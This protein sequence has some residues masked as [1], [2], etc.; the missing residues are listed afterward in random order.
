MA[1]VRAMISVPESARASQA[2]AILP[3]ISSDAD[4]DLAVEVSA[5]FGRGLV[6]ELQRTGAGAFVHAGGALNVEG[7][8]EAV[9]GVHHHRQVDAVADQ[10]HGLGHLGRGCQADVGPA[11]AGVGDG[12]AGKVERLEPGV[13]R[14]PAR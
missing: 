13:G 9:V 8:A 1:S 10:R 4:Q 2:A 5:P 14:Q 6:L 3:T 12:G 11:E 7:V